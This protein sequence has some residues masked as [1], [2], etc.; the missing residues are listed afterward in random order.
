MP[1]QTS[2]FEGGGSSPETRAANLAP[3][4]APAPAKAKKLTPEQERQKI[5]EQ[6]GAENAAYDT[7]A[8]ANYG[9]YQAQRNTVLDSM[10]AESDKQKAQ[11]DQLTK[12]ARDQSSKTSATY[13]DLG[14]RYQSAMEDAEKNASSAMSLQDYMNPNN[15]VAT[16]T[17]DLYETQANAEQKRGQADYGVLASLG[18]Q[19]AAN[20][21]SGLGPMTVGQQM[22]M[23]SQGQTKAA[24]AYAM[25]QK[26]IQAL[27]DQG[28]QM[29][30]ERSDKAY[31]AGQQAKDT[32]AARRGER[33]QVADDYDS[34]M[35]RYRGEIGG[36]QDESGAISN[37]ALQRRM[38]AGQE[39]YGFTSD[40]ASSTL[41][42]NQSLQGIKIADQDKRDALMAADTARRAAE[43]EARKNRSASMWN[44]IIGATGTIGGATAGALIGGPPGAAAGGAAGGTLANAATKK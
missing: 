30:F 16:S 12:D 42:R 13:T 26:R 23:Q 5:F 33:K 9:G 6:M 15:R 39:D 14:N 21:M 43:E 35:A 25:A 4:P 31:T 8:K 20:S 2:S 40:A 34:V 28:L 3:A 32:A 1:R 10:Q 17:R 19:A 38:M 29:G 27:R 18:S 37:A 7:T 41:Q 22:A 44:A 24:D 36:W 11:K